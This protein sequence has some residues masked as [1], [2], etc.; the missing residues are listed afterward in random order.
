MAALRSVID[1]HGPS[2]VRL[3]VGYAGWGPGQLE[4]ELAKGVWLPAAPD[5]ALLFDDTTSTLWQRAYQHSIGSIPA[6]FVGSTR[7]SA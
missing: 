3:L 6:A 4:S 2:E 7:G 1:G 5:A